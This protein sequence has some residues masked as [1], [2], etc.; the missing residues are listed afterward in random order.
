[1]QLLRYRLTSE[2]MRSPYN[3]IIKFNF[4]K[5]NDEEYESIAENLEE[6]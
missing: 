3:R 4:S 2:I 1:M 5:E 6:N